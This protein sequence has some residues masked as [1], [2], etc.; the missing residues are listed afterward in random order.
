M[1][2]SASWDEVRGLIRARARLGLAIV[3]LVTAWWAI[4]SPPRLDD[5]GVEAGLDELIRNQGLTVLPGSVLVPDLPPASGIGPLAWR[6]VLF[7][8]APVGDREGGDIFRAEARIHGERLLSA[9]D[10]HNLTRTSS[11]RELLLASHGHVSVWAVLVDGVIESI[12]LMDAARDERELDPAMP[13]TR[14]LL[15]H[16]DM[17]LGTGQWNGVGLSTY[18][19]L[20]PATRLDAK[21]DERGKRLHVTIYRAKDEPDGAFAIDVPSREVIEGG[22]EVRHRPRVWAGTPVIHWLVDTVRNLPWV[23][24]EPIALLEK[25]AFTAQD[26]A[27]RVGYRVGILH[28]KDIA[29]E[30][31]VTKEQVSATRIKVVRQTGAGGEEQGWPPPPVEPFYRKPRP[32]EGQWFP[33]ETDWL[34]RLPGAPPAFYKTAIRMPGETPTMVVLVAMDLRQL[35]LDMVAGLTTPW[36]STGNRGTGRIPREPERLARTVAAFNGG[37]QTAHG[38]FGMMVDRVLV[39]EPWQKTATLALMDDGTLRMGTWNNSIRVPEDMVSFRQNMPPLLE[40][41]VWNPTHRRH[42]GG[43][44]SDLDQVNTTRSA[45]GYR[46]PHT[47]VYAW[48][49][50][51]SAKGIAKAL[52]RAGCEY[53]MHL[54]MNPAHAGF[55]LLDIDP[56]SMDAKGRVSRFQAAKPV[57]AQSF[58]LERFVNRNGKDFFYLMLRRTIAD[59][60]PV[61]EGFG[62]WRGHVR[63]DLPDGFITVTALARQGDDT[64]LVAFDTRRLGSKVASASGGTDELSLTHPEAFVDLGDPDPERS[65]AH[66]VGGVLRGEPAAIW[67]TMVLD[68]A[69]PRILPPGQ[70]AGP[71]RDFV[72]G[73]PLVV[74]GEVS[75]KALVKAKPGV[76]HHALGVAADRA[77]LLY[78]TTTQGAEA[79]ARTLL[80]LGV[81]QAMLLPDSPAARVALVTGASAVDPLTQSRLPIDRV[82]QTRL[83]LERRPDRPRIQRLVMPDVEL[84]REELRRQRRIQARI[85][86]KREELRQISNEKY[87]EYI[88]RVR[89]RRAAKEAAGAGQ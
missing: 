44:I 11:A 65:M 45:V 40:D 62:P 81:D 10:F 31:G 17:K 36:S 30:L 43:T 88:E 37:F 73:V 48:S 15:A 23:G 18:A 46:G 51:V 76:R 86:E 21:F 58:D 2:R 19:L 82:H 80:G 70:G 38:P 26:W 74:G 83:Y 27:R 28:E 52:L 8:A 13:L 34:E 89:A 5:V 67:S 49:K 57:K 35:D 14:R 63:R 29:D 85:M 61:H 39:L 59:R 3:C 55:G 54:D 33:F 77:A 25:W 4:G 75:P 72:Q 47:L 50:H 42:W 78:L 69:G 9:R 53:G 12:L 60:L 6:S 68:E 64:L 20:V 56:T 24:P 84:S 66:R 22:D 7:S 71:V 16:V 41:G 1:D 87:H 32:G 79:M